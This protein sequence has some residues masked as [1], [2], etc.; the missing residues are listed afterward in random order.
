MIV[1]VT[2]R[3]GI[4]YFTKFE[5]IG[6]RDRL[7]V[8]L[9]IEDKDGRTVRIDLT[10]ALL[11][12]YAKHPEIGTVSPVA[13]SDVAPRAHTPVS[14][15]ESKTVRPAYLS[16]SKKEKDDLIAR[17]REAQ[18]RAAEEKKQKQAEINAARAERLAAAREAKAAK[19]PTKKT[20][21]KKPAASGDARLTKTQRSA[22]KKV[23]KALANEDKTAGRA[24]KSA[25]GRKPPAKATPAQ[26]PAP[27]ASK[28]AAKHTPGQKTRRVTKG[29]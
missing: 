11:D 28:S 3:R 12:E 27:S 19:P 23:G 20:A 14:I 5:D 16:E 8:E 13:V 22:I 1:C 7:E 24:A 2:Q 9:R 21:G 10:P 25:A 4:R 29:S 18:L 15:K 26:K 6:E 17:V